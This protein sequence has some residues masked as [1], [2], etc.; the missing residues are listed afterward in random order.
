[1]NTKREK[2]VLYDWIR[3]IATMMVVVGHSAYLYMPTSVGGVNYELPTL[4]NAI[5][6]SPIFEYARSAANWVYGFHMPLFFFL[7]GAVLALK[8][9]PEFDKFVIGKVKRLVVPFFVAGLFFMLP[10]K[11]FSGFYTSDSIKSAIGLFLSGGE[12]GHLWF[13]F[14][15]FW[16]MIVFV[17]LQKIIEKY[18]G[19]SQMLLWICTWMIQMSCLSIPFSNFSFTMGMMYI[20]WFGCGWI[21][22]KYGRKL[23]NIKVAVLLFIISTLLEWMNYR[24]IFF[25]SEAVMVIGMTWTISLSYI[26]SVLLKKCCDTVIYKVISRNLFNIY[27]F[28]D[29]LEYVVLKLAFTYGWLETESGCWAYLCGRTIGVIIVSIILGEALRIVINKAKEANRYFVERNC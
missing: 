10:V 4:T 16:V 17:V 21:F 19:N 5:Y 28:H 3:L 29:P 1:M 2:I 11:W 26:L 6:Y 25:T 9:I 12:S 24:Y 18:A 8:P 20:F 23:L 13:L 22:E 15:L 27:L 14:G 7:S